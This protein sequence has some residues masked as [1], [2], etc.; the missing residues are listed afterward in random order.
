LP[1]VAATSLAGVDHL[2]VSAVCF[3]D[4][5][6]QSH[7]GLWYRDHVNVIGH[8]AIGPDFDLPGTTEPGHLLPV[9]DIILVTEERLLPTVPR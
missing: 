8:Q 2:D 7:G 3:V 1:E 6:T 4:R 9:G 5:A